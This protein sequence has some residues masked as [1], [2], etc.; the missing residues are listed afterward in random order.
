MEKSVACKHELYNENNI[1]GNDITVSRVSS[2]SA[3]IAA[4]ENILSRQLVRELESKNEILSENSKLLQ[5]KIEFLNEKLNDPKKRGSDDSHNHK[6]NKNIIAGHPNSLKTKVDN[7]ETETSSSFAPSYANIINNSSPSTANIINSSSSTNVNTNVESVNVSNVTSQ[8]ANEKRII[9]KNNPS[10]DIKQ[11]NAAIHHA[12]ASSMVHELQ[13]LDHQK[14]EENNEQYNGEDWHRVNYRKRRFVVGKNVENTTISTVPKLVSLHVTRLKP[15]TDLNE[16]KQMLLP[17]FPEVICE[18]HVSRLLN[19]SY[20]QEKKSEK[21][22]EV[23]CV[24]KW[25]L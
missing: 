19:E 15:N 24:A 7:L 5:E 2:E 23:R 17:D 11:V 22:M 20:N 3:G 6:N 14:Q 8:N 25:R 18:K 9:N 4:A 21:S 16:L 12:K 1:A 10:F 13:Q